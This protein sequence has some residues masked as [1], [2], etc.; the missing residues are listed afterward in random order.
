MK[1][2]NSIT[3]ALN[4]ILDKKGVGRI[5]AVEIIEE[6]NV[7]LY[8]LITGLTLGIFGLYWLY[9]IA[10]DYEKHFKHHRKI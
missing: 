8:A 2:E 1:Y 3:T 7:L 5:E 4:K 6:R 10:S 9:A